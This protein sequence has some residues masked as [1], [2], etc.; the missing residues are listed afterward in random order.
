MDSSQ[1]IMKHVCLKAK[2][3]P[4]IDTNC[5]DIVLQI[6]NIIIKRTNQQKVCVARAMTSTICVQ[7]ANFNQILAG[8]PNIHIHT[9]RLAQINNRES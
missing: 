6:Y 2:H 1:N 3:M 9:T 8:N 4:S 5:H 7:H